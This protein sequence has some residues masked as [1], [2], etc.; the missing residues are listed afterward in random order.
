MSDGGGY[1]AGGDGDA[2]G[3]AE[4]HRGRQRSGAAR[5]GGADAAAALVVPAGVV[6][7]GA[8]HLLG[9]YEPLLGLRALQPANLRRALRN[10]RH[11]GTNTSNPTSRSPPSPLWA[12]WPSGVGRLAAF[13]FKISL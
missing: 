12:V 13:L 1:A 5:L 3:V 7:A 2:G 11:A 6:H 10:A 8:A 4:R 9:V